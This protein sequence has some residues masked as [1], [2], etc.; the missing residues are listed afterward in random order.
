MPVPAIATGIG[1]D[2]S[3]LTKILNRNKELFSGLKGMVVMATTGGD[4][5]TLCLN[6]DGVIGLIMKLDVHRI[7]NADKRDRVLKFQ[8]WAVEVLGKIVKGEIP[9]Q[10]PVRKESPVMIAQRAK[11]FAREVGGNFK[12]ILSVMLI[13][14]GH[15]YLIRALPATMSEQRPLPLLTEPKLQPISIDTVRNLDYLN[16]SQIG[17]LAVKTGR[18]INQWLYNQGYIVKDEK[19]EWRLTQSGREVGGE[20][21]LF[22]PV[23][24]KIVYSIY[25]NRAAILKK[26]NIQDGRTP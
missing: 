13:E 25:W 26:M 20:E 14:A 1:Y 6:H 9:V 8:R 15:G 24:G 11:R 10:A 21:R 3:G 12:E 16:A 17:M 5:D 23:K 19:H 18:E 4:Q 2:R 22:E 7:K